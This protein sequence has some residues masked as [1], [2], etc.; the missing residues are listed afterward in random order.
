MDIYKIIN[1]CYDRIWELTIVPARPIGPLVGDVML[2]TYCYAHVY[3]NWCTS[4]CIAV[5]VQLMIN[6][7]GN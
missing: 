6:I 1:Y 5:W 4:E 7:H 2:F 3:C